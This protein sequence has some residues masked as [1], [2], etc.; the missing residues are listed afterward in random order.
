MGIRDYPAKLYTFP[1]FSCLSCRIK[2]QVHDQAPKTAMTGR[3]VT[4]YLLRPISFTRAS[5]IKKGASGR[6]VG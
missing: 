1:A 2:L 5:L 6:G 4:Q 3:P